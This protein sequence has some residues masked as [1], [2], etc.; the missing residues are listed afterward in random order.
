MPRP[1][2]DGL[3]WQSTVFDLVPVWTRE[4]STAAIESVCRQQLQIRPEDTLTVTFHAQGAYNRVYLVHTDGRSFIMRVT[5]PVY[6]RHKTRAEVVTLRWVHDTTSLPVPQVFGYD[7][8]NDNEI[9]FEWILMEYMPGKSLWKQWRWISM[10]KKVALAEQFAV[11]QSELSGLGNERPLFTNI[12]TLEAPEID[13][14]TNSS[15][16]PLSEARQITTAPGR[17]VSQQFFLGNHLG[18]EM[19]RGPFRSSHDW[20]SAM[21]GVIIQHQTNVLNKPDDDDDAEEAEE[22]LAAARTL[23]ALIP[24]IFPSDPLAGPEPSALYHHDLNLNNILVD[25]EGQVTAVL[26]W[27]CVSALPLWM[28]TQTPAFLYDRAREDEPQRDLYGDESPEEAAEQANLKRNNH[29]DYLDNEGKD[30][31]YWINKMEYETTQLRKVY[32]ARLKKSCPKWV[33]E[34]P[35]KADFHEAVSQ[36]DG[37][38]V[39]RV[40]RWAERIDKGDSIRFRDDI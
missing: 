18:Y 19:P 20:L 27:E 21:L 37:P 22:I 25:E 2:Q 24:K 13:L 9:G 35:L 32:Q 14:G 26:D 30:E 40:L 16:I 12:G 31:L 7:D 17:L 1:T 28:V 34:S 5:L 36:C 4:P 10:E 33:E 15:P 8:S 11:F 23:V 3:E 29:P 39:R 38:W 6:P